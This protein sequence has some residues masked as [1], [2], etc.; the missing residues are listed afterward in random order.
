MHHLEELGVVVS[1]GSACHAKAGSTSP[2]LAASGG[3]GGEAGHVL[4]FSVSR[5]TTEAEVSAAGDALESV[6]EKLESARL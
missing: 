2:A 1:A 5:S 3:G 6:C 4:R